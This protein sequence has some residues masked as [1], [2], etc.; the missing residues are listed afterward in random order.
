MKGVIVCIIEWYFL[1]AVDLLK[2]IG[3]SN[4]KIEFVSAECMHSIC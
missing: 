2:K 3:C 1:I 4:V